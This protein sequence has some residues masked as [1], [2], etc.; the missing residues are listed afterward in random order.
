[1]ERRKFLR[2]IA[3]ASI[4]TMVPAPLVAR[5]LKELDDVSPTGLGIMNEIEDTQMN[6]YYLITG[7][8]GMRM[9]DE[10]IKAI[11]NGGQQI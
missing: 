4:A 5:A 1:M 8:E 3:K 11:Y 9:F 2:K 10:A 6:S 7:E